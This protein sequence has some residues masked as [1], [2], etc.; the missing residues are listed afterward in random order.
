M[1]KFIWVLSSIAGINLM[2]IGFFNFDILRMLF[3]YTV[4]LK[5]FYIIL[6]ACALYTG[7]IYKRITK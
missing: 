7:L 6:G 3:G 5:T 4:I 1:K 2:V